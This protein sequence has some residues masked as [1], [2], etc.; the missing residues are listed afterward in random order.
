MDEWDTHQLAKSA[1]NYVYL[2]KH[3]NKHTHRTVEIIATNSAKSQQY[4]SK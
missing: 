4:R 3:T 2:N 1:N